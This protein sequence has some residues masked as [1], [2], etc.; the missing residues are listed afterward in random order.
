M[1]DRRILYTILTRLLD[2]IEVYP[3]TPFL[4]RTL[5]QMDAHC[6]TVRM[7]AVGWAWAEACR[8]LDEG[9]DPRTTDM[10]TLAQRAPKELNSYNLNS[11]ND[12]YEAAPP[13][14]RQN[15][16]AAKSSEAES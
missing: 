10:A 6:Q 7:Q 11:Y 14:N 9:K 5:A 2:T 16:E 13:S 1:D 3:A 15:L 4:D 8:L 12:E